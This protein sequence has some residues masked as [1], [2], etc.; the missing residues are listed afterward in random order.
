[1][2][3]KHHSRLRQESNPQ[4]RTSIRPSNFVVAGILGIATLGCVA[5]AQTASPAPAPA[6]PS[7]SIDVA[8]VPAAK[9]APSPAPDRST[10]Y[11]H[12]ALA[13]SYEDMATNY[14]RQEFFSK[15]IEE[16]KYAISADPNS[17][18]LAIGLA[19]LYLRANRIPEA[20]QTDLAIIMSD[21]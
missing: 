9:P 21:D 6:N 14:G 13:D 18:E 1:M 4:I 12:A 15:A 17:S 16:Y 2:T 19:E 20:F 10:A 11:Y 5:L 3:E 8:P 7:P